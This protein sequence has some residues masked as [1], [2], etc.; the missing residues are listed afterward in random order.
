MAIKHDTR[1][2]HRLIDLS[3]KR[4]G[5]WEVL[6]RSGRSQALQ[7]QW[8]CRCDCGKEKVVAGQSLRYGRSQS[9]GCLHRELL[10]S[11]R[12]D[13]RSFQAKHER[14][15]LLLLEGNQVPLLES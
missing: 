5:R 4:F 10:Q 7:P 8:L 11:A 9:C 6:R 15:D 2:G 3:G 12:N 1:K 13:P 14:S